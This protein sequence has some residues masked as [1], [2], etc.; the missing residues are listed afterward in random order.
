MALFGQFFVKLRQVG[1]LRIFLILIFASL[2]AY[3]GYLAFTGP[4][5][6]SVPLSASEGELVEWGRNCTALARKADMPIFFVLD[7]HDFRCSSDTSDILRKHYVKTVLDPEAF[8]A[9]YRVL[10]RIFAKSGALGEP[11]MGILSSRGFPVYLS[12]SLTDKSKI[13]RREDSA[14]V[15]ALNAYIN[16]RNDLNSGVKI[17]VKLASL[18]PKLSDFSVAFSGE[19]SLGLLENLKL[20]FASGALGNSPSVFTENCRIAAR[21]SAVN[22]SVLA[23]QVRDMALKALL[24]SS[25]KKLDTKRKLLTARALSEFVFTG[26]YP[27]AQKRFFEMLNDLE[28]SVDCSGFLLS[29]NKAKTRENA[30]LL[31]LY[32]RAYMM[33]GGDYYLGKIESLSS[34][35]SERL[36]ENYMYPALLLKDGKRVNS[37]ASAIDYS[38]LV[39]AWL[40]SY[41]ATGNTD[42]LRLTMNSLDCFDFEFS[43][44]RSGAWFTNAKSSIFAES[45]RYKEERDLEYPSSIGEG[46]QILS[47][48][49]SMRGEIPNRLFRILSPLNSFFN[50]RL[51]DRA[52]LKLAII[53][54]PMLK[55]RVH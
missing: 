52:S 10:Q 44:P 27:I 47:D 25:I 33:G 43:D 49:H 35:L 2:S 20:V 40:D 26:D 11:R 9:D 21:I 7:G 55:L 50:F 34:K 8:P 15:G 4:E 17:A 30:L 5:R 39:R 54:N 53:E 23:S 46:A 36:F 3:F 24:D 1:K 32:A 14:I 6:C 38:L 31:S 19:N 29:S 13:K 22:G 48:I 16:R 18:E 12:N 28:K 45:F 42:Y 41:L 37:E 51:L